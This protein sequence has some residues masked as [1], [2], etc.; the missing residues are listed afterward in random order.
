MAVSRLLLFASVMGAV[1]PQ[2]G[3]AQILPLAAAEYAAKVE[4]VT[5]QVSVLRDSQPWALSPG[6]VVQCQQIILS[7]PNG[8]ALM[9]VSDG[10]TFEVF[11]N[12][13]VVFRRNVPNW[14]D[15]LD[16]VIGK[17][18]VHINKIGGVPNPNRVVTPTAVISVR[19]TTFEVSVDDEE[20]STLVEVEEGE[21]AVEHALLARSTQKILRDGESLKVYKNMPLAAKSIDKGNIVKYGMRAV[22]DAINTVILRPGRVGGI[23]GA[24]GGGGTVGLPGDSG[25]AAPPP[26]PPPP[27]PPVAPPPGN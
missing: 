26:P 9:R 24:T 15:L 18:R 27:P 22:M 14:R 2:L 20:E 23:P 12:S 17:V 5:G 8:Y 6:D 1:C 19:G 7:G 11:S 4:T 16:V 10:S 3:S 25:G 13:Q 21:V